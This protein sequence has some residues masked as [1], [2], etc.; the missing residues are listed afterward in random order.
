M[1]NYDH[2]AVRH[3]SSSIDSCQCREQI[4]RPVYHRHATVRNRKMVEISSQ[5]RHRVVMAQWTISQYRQHH[6]CHCSSGGFSSVILVIPCK[7]QAFRT[8]CHHPHLHRELRLLITSP[9]LNGR[10]P[11]DRDV[12]CM[13]R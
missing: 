1:A 11:D 3:S 4:A 13:W 5:Q 2:S 7:W 6:S 10:A 12:R 8:A 9:H